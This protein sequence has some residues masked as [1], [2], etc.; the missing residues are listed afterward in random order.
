MSHLIRRPLSAGVRYL[1]WLLMRCPQNEE[2]VVSRITEPIE[3][4]GS[5]VSW[6][7]C[8]ACGGWHVTLIEERQ[9]LEQGLKYSGEL[10]A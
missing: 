7:Q 9:N 4:A 2:E 5:W 6:W 3:F 1:A 10:A 8:P